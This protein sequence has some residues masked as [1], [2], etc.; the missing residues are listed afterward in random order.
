VS[1]F[2]HFNYVLLN[3]SYKGEKIIALNVMEH[4]KGDAVTS[5]V[6]K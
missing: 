6:T 3:Y 4:K 2:C 5:N 1:V